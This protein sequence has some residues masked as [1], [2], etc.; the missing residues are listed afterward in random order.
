MFLQ[1]RRGAFGDTD[2]GD[3]L[4]TALDLIDE[5]GRCSSRAVVNV[6]GDGR[7]STGHRGSG[8]VP[9]SVARARAETMGV[10]V[11][12]LA[13]LNSEPGLDDYY[14]TNLITGP[15]SFVIEAK[16]FRAFG[17][18][19][20]QKLEREIKPQLSASIDAENTEGRMHGSR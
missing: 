1:A 15:G 12:G 3:G 13:I 17:E 9:V 14:R 6:S 18:A 7:A 20:V 16:D 8:R 4:M 2:L 10:T 5:P 11:N 19:I